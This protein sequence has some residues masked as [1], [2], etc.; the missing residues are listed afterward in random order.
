M[1]FLLS[2]I[3]EKNVMLVF[4][5]QKTKK[6]SHLGRYTSCTNF[7]LV[8]FCLWYSKLV[9]CFFLIPKL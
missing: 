5:K 1:S 7:K 8:K 9:K 6:T 3:E 2:I 4:T